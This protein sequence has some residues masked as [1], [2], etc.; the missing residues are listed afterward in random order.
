M[1]DNYYQDE[2][3]SKIS[4]GEVCLILYKTIL[5][6]G[7]MNKIIVST[8]LELHRKKCISFKQKNDDIC[9]EIE[10]PNGNL[11]ESELLIYQCLKASDNEKDGVLTL[12]EI[13]NKK[14][15]IFA[16][17]KR[18]IKDAIIKESI[19]DGYIDKE[20]LEKKEKLSSE[21]ILL[22]IFIP[23]IFFAITSSNPSPFLFFFELLLLLIL[24]I[25]AFIRYQKI[26]FFTKKF[27]EE[28]H[29]LLGLKDYLK[30]YS[31]IEN[32]NI[33]DIYLWERY[34]SFS[35]AF[36]LNKNIFDFLKINLKDQETLTEKPNTTF[37]KQFDFYENK[38]FYIND[39][40][41]KIYI[42]N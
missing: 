23:F 13:S 22:L 8:I 7:I 42:D 25:S 39:K 15:K 33:L 3:D 21:C 36:D 16:K 41:E 28:K 38:Y 10:N 9:I 37:E 17:N 2:I 12:N 1:K 30:D 11:K 32:K 29:K 6:N 27:E 35:V 4:M 40:N 26:N 18:K 20:K 31:L 24:N 5:D 19:L 34:L 14:N